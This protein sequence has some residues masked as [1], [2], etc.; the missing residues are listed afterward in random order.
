[1]TKLVSQRGFL[2]D[3]VKDFFSGRKSCQLLKRLVENIT[4][5]H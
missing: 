5:K 4:M 2:R 1:M 3:M